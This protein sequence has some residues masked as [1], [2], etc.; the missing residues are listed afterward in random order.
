MKFCSECG[1][2]LNDG[3]KFCPACGR[4]LGAAV[5]KKGAW[6]K[7][8]L[9]LAGVPGGVIAALLIFVQIQNGADMRAE[10]E[11]RAQTAISLSSPQDMTADNP[12][13]NPNEPVETVLILRRFALPPGPDD[14]I[15]TPSQTTSGGSDVPGQGGPGLKGPD[16][17]PE[18]L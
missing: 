5:K 11:R 9:V 17:L 2:A 10:R 4:Q 16:Q 6:W 12:G 15:R 1:G 3:A 7:W 13:R 8:A 14:K 18:P